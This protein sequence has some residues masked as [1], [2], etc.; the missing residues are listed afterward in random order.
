M[1]PSRSFIFILLIAV[2]GC[3]PAQTIE[4]KEKIYAPVESTLCHI[5]QKVASHFLISGIPDGFNE[6]QYRA[7]VKEGCYS[8]PVCKSQ[9]EAIFASYGVDARKID[10]IFSVMLCDKEM[11]RKIM[12]DFSCNHLLVEVH[13]WQEAGNVVCE[14]EIDWERIKREKCKE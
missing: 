7:A 2:V 5:N 10:D 12:E 9:A 1:H 4:K 3:A 11:R 13:S 8:N 6:A 14:F